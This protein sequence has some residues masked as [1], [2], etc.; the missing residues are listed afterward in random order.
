[1]HLL[2][3]L[4]GLAGIL[5]LTRS[6]KQPRIGTKFTVRAPDGSGHV[7]T[8]SSLGAG[9]GWKADSIDTV[10]HFASGS[11]VKIDGT[12]YTWFPALSAFVQ[13]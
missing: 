9:N 3:G 10:N 5:Y 2:I 1:M 4:A 6:K 7:V 8:F 12:N 11:V 13:V